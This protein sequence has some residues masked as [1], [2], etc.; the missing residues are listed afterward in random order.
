[1]YEVKSKIDGK[2]YAA[3]KLEYQI[4]NKLGLN[5]EEK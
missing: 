4:G 1:V 2:I 3:K 5:N